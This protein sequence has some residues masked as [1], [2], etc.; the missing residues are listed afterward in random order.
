[1]FACTAKVEPGG[2]TSRRQQRHEPHV[3]RNTPGGVQD[4]VIK[5]DL[6]KQN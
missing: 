6:I 1:M 3:S 2:G 5:S 4:D